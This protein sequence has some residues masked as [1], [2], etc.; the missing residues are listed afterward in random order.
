M[1]VILLFS[2]VIVCV[3]GE[4]D[5]DVTVVLFYTPW[6]EVTYSFFCAMEQLS[7]TALPLGY[8]IE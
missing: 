5:A 7:L 8:N 6:V 1:I 4:S 2:L 3:C